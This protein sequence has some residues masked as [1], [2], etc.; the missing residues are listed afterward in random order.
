MPRFDSSNPLPAGKL[1]PRLLSELLAELP[2]RAK[3]LLMGPGIGED[4][5]VVS[6]GATSLIAKADPVTFATDLI[7]WYAVHVNANDIAATGATPKWFMPTVLLPEGT[8][9]DTVQSIFRQVQ[10]AAESI[11]VGLIGGHTE[12]TDGVQRPIISGAMLGEAPASRTVSTSGA[13]PGDSI[14]LTKGIAI[15]GT[16]LLARE[17]RQQALVAGIPESVLETAANFLFEP[18]ISVIRDAS[19]ATE[20]GAVTAMHDPTEGGLASA[21]AEVSKASGNGLTIDEAAVPIFEECQTLCDSL[22]VDP[23]GLISSGAL[24]ITCVPESASAI[25]ESLESEEIPAAVIGEMTGRREPALIR[26]PDSSLKPLPVFQRDEIAR[27]FS[28]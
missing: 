12:I 26:R 25:V 23:W 28:E 14:I 18:G 17:F 2:E 20:A 10:E 16:S 8:P 1:P 21:L 6:F 24:L 5:A 22:D 9:P 4:A 13:K 11:G 15:E 19:I 27:I 7:G 3:R